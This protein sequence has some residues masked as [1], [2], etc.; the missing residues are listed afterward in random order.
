MLFVELSSKISD[1][2][3]CTCSVFVYEHVWVTTM[4]PE[5]SSD[6]W[7]IWETE[8]V[9]AEQLRGVVVRVQGS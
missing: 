2:L 7:A 9:V 5:Q 3:V 4:N 1:W 8:S 6:L